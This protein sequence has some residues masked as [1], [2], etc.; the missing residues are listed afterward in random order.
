MT[1]PIADMLTR[2]RNAQMVNK[3]TVNVPYSSLKF[4]VSKL[5][6][7]TRFISDVEKKDKE[8]GFPVIEITLKKDGITGIERVS[9]PGQRIYEKAQNL[10]VNFKYG[11]GLVVM[12][13]SQGVMEARKAKGSQLGGEVLCRVW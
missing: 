12:S 10:D 11:R 3:R 4:E 9:K 7:T 2:I 5:L 13:T 1:D 6:K 8:E